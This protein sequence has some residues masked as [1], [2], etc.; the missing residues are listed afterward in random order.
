MT[1]ARVPR[2]RRAIGAPKVA[3]AARNLAA[4]LAVPWGLPEARDYPLEF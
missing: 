4:V 1:P 3:L 2:D